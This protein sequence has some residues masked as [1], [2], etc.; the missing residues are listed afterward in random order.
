MARA[1]VCSG[2]ERDGIGQ[3]KILEVRLWQILLQKWVA[4]IV[5]Q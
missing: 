3:Q 1:H 2:P 4:G 5:E